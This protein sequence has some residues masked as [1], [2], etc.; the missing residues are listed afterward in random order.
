[1]AAERRIHQ[2]LLKPPLFLGVTL[3]VLVAEVAFLF[4]VFIAFGASKVVVVYA[5]LTLLLAHP[6]LARLVDRDPLALRLFAESLSYRR[7]YPARGSLAPSAGVKP[8]SCLPR[9]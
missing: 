7:F 6:L 4:G 8:R 1:M 2:S 9:V 3:D 5:L